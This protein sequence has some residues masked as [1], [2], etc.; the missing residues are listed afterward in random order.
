LLGFPLSVAGAT[1]SL[2]KDGPK[3]AREGD[4]IE[5]SFEVVNEGVASV[6]GIEVLDTLPAEVQFVQATPTTGGAYN[7]ITGV[8]VLPTL[9]MDT[10]D[11]TAGLQIQALVNQNLINNPNDVVG[12]TNKAEVIAPL[13]QT[14]LDAQVNTNI[15]CTFCIDWEIASVTFDYEIGDI[16][17]DDDYDQEI[18]ARFFLRVKVANNGPVASDAT[19]SVTHFDIRSGGFGTVKL[20]PDVPVSVVLDPGQAQTIEFKTAWVEGDDFG[21]L[22][23]WEF[24][25]NDVSL[26][27]P[28]LPNTATGSWSDQ[29]DNGGSSGGGCFIATAAYGSY[30][31]PHVV[32]LRDFRDQHLLTYPLG[33]WFVGIYYQHS[34]P[35]ADYIREHERLRMIVRSVLALVVYS[36]EYPIAAVLT[37]LIPPLLLTYQRKRRENRTFR[38]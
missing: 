18:D 30:L 16:S 5:Y 3:T 15:I 36:I 24:E 9:G 19:V 13:D 38:L 33:E 7:S 37:F 22:V 27:D 28:I 25:V 8:W 17:F 6:A 11:K 23:S 21:W 32:T 4:L 35:I 2:V 34:P 26:L 29:D 14:P 12:A 31:A 20:F 10:N 1:L